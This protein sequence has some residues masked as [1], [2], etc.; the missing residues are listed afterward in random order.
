VAGGYKLGAGASLPPLSLDEDEATAVF[1]GLHAAAGTG[2]R[3]PAKEEWRTFRLDRV[4]RV[5]PENERFRA[6]PP[7]ED[8]LVA[9]VTRSIS[10]A[11]HAYRAKVLLHAP[12]D[13]VRPR[14]GPQDGHFVAVSAT[15]CTMELGAPTLDVLVSRI[16]WLGVDFEVLAS[17]SLRLHLR[18]VAARLARA[19]DA[20][21]KEP[22]VKTH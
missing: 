12:L 19:R 22:A 2:V 4:A 8:D 6:R 15:R 5:A 14:V 16:L 3:D 10:W 7:P 21:D 20:E 9:Y 13:E 1:V 18:T 11:A 17:D